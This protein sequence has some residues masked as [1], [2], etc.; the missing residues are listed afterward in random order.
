MGAR[1]PRARRPAPSRDLATLLARLA[2]ARAAASPAGGRVLVP[3][4]RCTYGGVRAGRRLRSAGPRHDAP[5]VL[6]APV[7][8]T[9]SRRFEQAATRP[10]RLVRRRARPPPPPHARPCQRGDARAQLGSDPAARA[11]ELSGARDRP[12]PRPVRAAPAPARRSGAVSRGSS[13]SRRRTVPARSPSHEQPSATPESDGILT[14]ARASRADARARAELPSRDARTRVAHRIDAT[15]V[16][17]GVSRARSSAA[18]A[19]SHARAGSLRGAS[20]PFGAPTRRAGPIRTAAAR[21]SDG[22]QRTRPPSSSAKEARRAEGARAPA[23]ARGAHGVPG[24]GATK[25]DAQVDSARD[26]LSPAID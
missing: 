9:P 15:R 4:S 19:Q 23:R 6:R 21:V 10:E 2:R 11:R 22:H 5:P 17:F 12:R 3:H 18:Q 7:R 8:A 16:V 1:S 26:V 14:L 25:H 13:H 20:A 24:A